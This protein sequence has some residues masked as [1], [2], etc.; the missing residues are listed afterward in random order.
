MN[1]QEKPIIILETERQLRIYMLPLRQR[2]LRMMHVLGKPVTSKQLA[3]LLELAPS[4]ARHH[5]ARLREIGLV[6]H[7]H[8]EMINGIRA[9]YVRLTDV[10]VSI[11]ADRSDA[12]GAQRESI[13]RSLLD[14]VRERYLTAV[15]SHSDHSQFS[16][17]MLTGI[18]HLRPADAQ[19]LY[20][21][22]RSFVEAHAQVTEPESSAWEYAFILFNPP[23]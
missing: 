7:D 2:I 23:V 8:H 15:R 17:D 18:A 12:L 4:S 13:S 9:E 21:L 20:Q 1:R 6:E 3:D 5:L 22:V 10:V 14:S 19:K 16:G 11:G